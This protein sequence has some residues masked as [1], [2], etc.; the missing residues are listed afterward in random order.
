MRAEL[1]S[2]RKGTV[3][4]LPENFGSGNSGTHSPKYSDQH[5]V[6]NSEFENSVQHSLTITA[7]KKSDI[8]KAQI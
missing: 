6:Q 5:T 3:P 8:T 2:A 4:K 1:V 7:A